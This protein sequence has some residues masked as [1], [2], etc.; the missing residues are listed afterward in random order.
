MIEVGNRDLTGTFFGVSRRTVRALTTGQ[1][2]LAR[3]T[4]IAKE[5]R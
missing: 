5:R 1:E 4:F 3:R 2:E